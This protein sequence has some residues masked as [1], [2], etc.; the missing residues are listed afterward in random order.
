[1]IQT[2]RSCASFAALA[3]GFALS[4]GAAS[5]ES[6]WVTITLLHTNDV[7]EISPDKGIGGLAS[8]KT[9]LDQ[10]RAQS[11]H[12]I[13]TFGGDLLSPSVLSSVT[14]GAHMIDLYNDLGTDF[15]VAGNHEFDFGPEVA[16]ARF[17]ESDFVWLGANARAADGSLAFDFTPKTMLEFG[18]VKVGLFGILHPVTQTLS[19]P[20]DAIAFEDPIKV[21]QLMVEELKADGADV[22]VAL[23][24]LN[25]ADDLAFAKALDGVDLV[26]S[27]DDHVPRAVFSGDT[28]VAEA[29]Y[30]ARRLLAVDLHVLREESEEGV[31]VDVEHSYRLISTRGVA[32]DA[33][34]GARVAALEAELD[35]ALEEVLVRTSVEWD[36]QRA[37]VR[38]QETNFGSLSA[39]A[40]AASVGADF[41]ITNGG[42]I[43]GDKV[44]PAGAQITVR[45]ILTELPFG[46]VVVLLELTGQEVWDALENGV[47]Q[48]EDVAGR[49]P[50]VSEALRFS[51]DS[52]KPAGARVTSVDVAGDPIDLEATYR[53]ALNDYIARG[54]DGYEAFRSGR[55]VID[56]SSATL[57]AT[58]VADF[59]R[60]SERPGDIATGRITN[61]GQT[62]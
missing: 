58:Q 56:A 50:Q 5:A 40:M 28:L 2:E 21:G 34:I 47:S 18:G 49:F 36:T 48:V 1:M 51:Y 17:S 16:K 44:Y 9:L 20:G 61:E 22:I 55:V 19:S 43:R 23:V 62:P 7:Y 60:A 52:G 30:D 26:L 27:G 3:L 10:E 41:G 37:N 8:L 15:A 29:G 38:T 57:M 6:S 45:D 12:T 35:S 33:Q 53:V 11:Q 31:E 39:D 13:T 54:G 42:G 32:E 25:F 14:K 4:H 46:N 59:I 24:H